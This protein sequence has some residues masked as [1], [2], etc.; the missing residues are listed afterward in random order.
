MRNYSNAERLLRYQVPSGPDRKK[1]YSFVFIGALLAG[2]GI[3]FVISQ[4][5][6]TFHSQTDLRQVT[7][8]AILGTIPMVWTDQEKYKRR[9]R[10]YAFGFSLLVLMVLYTTLMIYTKLPVA[11]LIKLF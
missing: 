8:L 6:P 2:I 5:R 3:A 11:T 10:L 1:L 9:N 7:G 4:I